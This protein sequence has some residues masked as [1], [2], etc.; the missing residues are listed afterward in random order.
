MNK[1]V[2]YS[3][4][5]SSYGVPQWSVLGPI[6]F[7]L[8]IN[9]LPLIFPSNIH[10]NLFADD[11]IIYFSYSNINQRDHLS[12]FFPIGVKPGNLM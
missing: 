5:P 6:L 11:T 10:I 8:Y 2:S 12:I 1:Y 3:I 4:Y 7:L 9:D